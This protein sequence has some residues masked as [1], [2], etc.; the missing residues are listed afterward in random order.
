MKK[1]KRLPRVVSQA[2]WQVARD[3]LLRKEK[4]Q[5]RARDALAAERRRLPMVKIDKNYVFE[6]SDGKTRLVDLFDGRRQLILYH[7]MFAPGVD[8]WPKAG[9]SRLFVRRRPHRPPRPPPCPQHLV[10]AGVPRSTRQHQAVQAAD[11]LDRAVVFL[12]GQRLQPRPRSHDGR[13]RNVRPERVSPGRPDGLSHLF[14]ERARRR[15]ARHSL[16]VSRPDAIRPA[17]NLGRLPQRVAADAT[18]S[19]VATTR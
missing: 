3:K 13:R 14:H 6:G 10:G 9:L 18:V 2:E 8:G 19:L 7:F 1:H 17:G 15:D 16:D 12:V 4:A 5:T 11:G